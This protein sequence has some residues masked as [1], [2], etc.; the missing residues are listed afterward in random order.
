MAFKKIVLETQVNQ[1]Y[2]EKGWKES[3]DFRL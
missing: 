2:F 3:S 1:N